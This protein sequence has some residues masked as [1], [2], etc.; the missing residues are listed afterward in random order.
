[1]D[2]EMERLFQTKRDRTKTGAKVGNNEIRVSGFERGG[3]WT[4]S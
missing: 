1:M 3:R 4:S 2:L